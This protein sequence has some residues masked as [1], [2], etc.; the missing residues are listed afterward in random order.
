MDPVEINKRE[1]S[2]YY[3]RKGPLAGIWFYWFMLRDWL[4]SSLAYRCPHPGIT[5]MLN[6]LRGVNI[7]KHVYIGLRV[8]VDGDY[9][10]LVTIEDYVSIGMNTMIYAHSNPTYSLELKRDCYPR[11]VATTTIKRGSW[12]AP[13]CIILAGITIGENAVVGTGSV[14]TKNVDPYSVVAGNPAR[15]IKTLPRRSPDLTV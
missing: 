5:V 14:V 11:R 13:G 9:P 1:L 3:G 6:R 7:G 8:F 10:H 15:L 4:L 12:V 2:E